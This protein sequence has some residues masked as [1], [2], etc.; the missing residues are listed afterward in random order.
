[1]THPFEIRAPEAHTQA[2]LAE[3]ARGPTDEFRLEQALEGL[4]RGEPGEDVEKRTGRLLFLA[5]LSPERRDLDTW[6]SHAARSERPVELWL[7]SVLEMVPQASSVVEAD[8]EALA[9]IH[10]SLFAIPAALGRD[11]PSLETFRRPAADLDALWE[12]WTPRIQALDATRGPRLADFFDRASAA[13]LVSRTCLA[14]LPPDAERPK[15]ARLVHAIGTFAQVPRLS[16]S[17]LAGLEP[18]RLV[19]LLESATQPTPHDV[20]AAESL[21]G[22]LDPAADET[23]ARARSRLPDH[24]AFLD[25]LL[26]LLVEKPDDRAVD[27]LFDVLA[28]HK[29]CGFGRLATQALGRIGTPAARRLAERFDEIHAELPDAI[30]LVQ[31]LSHP[32][33]LDPVRR[34]FLATGQLGFGEALE[35]LYRAEGVTD[36]P[37]GDLARQLEAIRSEGPEAIESSIELGFPRAPKRVRVHLVCQSCGR[38]FVQ[39]LVRLFVL[40]PMIGNLLEDFYYPED[41]A[42]PWCRK[43]GGHPIDPAHVR[44]LEKYFRILQRLSEA[45]TD[46][47]SLPFRFVHFAEPET[48]QER[49]R[50]ALG[51]LWTARQMFHK[52]EAE[53]SAGIVYARL[54]AGIG[55]H[56]RAATVMDQVL[57]RGRLA[58]KELLVS[59][60]VLREIGSPERAE[61]LESEV[62]KAAPKRGWEGVGRNDPCPCGSGKKYK[63]CCMP[64]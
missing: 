14:N 44:R 54:L 6:F 57:A 5:L 50:S 9:G 24:R 15:V 34:A 8:D 7:R 61:E 63:K 4:R 41:L 55:E 62:A 39:D 17:D 58:P 13:F 47:A 26:R 3:P 42:C 25:V 51:S 53:P 28:E 64:Q 1:M 23:I 45:G 43:I 49:Q 11:V 10:A 22:R 30:G 37:D 32:S 59:A 2:G 12:L 18:G 27:F 46:F 48:G 33:L 29:R 60:Q 38:S 36:R 52:P 35:K 56:T 40:D 19:D 16:A 31:D 20:A 21:A